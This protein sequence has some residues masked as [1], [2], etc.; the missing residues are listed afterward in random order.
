MNAET[1]FQVEVKQLFAPDGRDSVMK[2]VLPLNCFS[3]VSEMQFAGLHFEAEVLS[4][5]EVSISISSDDEDV[6]MEIVPNGPSVQEAMKA[7]LSRRLWRSRGKV[8]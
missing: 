5:G 7:M 8:L 3:D 4:T 2:T 1:E 6:D